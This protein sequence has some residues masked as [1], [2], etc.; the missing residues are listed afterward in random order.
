MQHLTWGVRPLSGNHSGVFGTH[1][2]SLQ[3]SL[4][5]TVVPGWGDTAEPA[6]TAQGVHATGLSLGQDQGAAGSV[7]VPGG[8]ACPQRI[9]AGATDLKGAQ[10]VRR[11]PGSAVSD[12]QQSH[13]G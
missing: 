9:P 8:A 3:Q 7:M 4:E 2:P 5:R 6:G 11:G 1:A 10:A 12:Q 13:G